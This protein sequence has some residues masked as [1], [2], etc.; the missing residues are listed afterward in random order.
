MSASVRDQVFRAVVADG[1]ALGAVALDRTTRAV[2][3]GHGHEQLVTG[4]LLDLLLGTVAPSGPLT[5]LAGGPPVSEARELFVTAKDR[6]LF[7]SV[8]PT[9]EVIVLATPAAMSVA[10]GWA[11]ARRLITAMEAG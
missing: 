3:A 9:G 5:R 1:G 10:L 6:S 7:V 2:I 4:T 11:L 8:L